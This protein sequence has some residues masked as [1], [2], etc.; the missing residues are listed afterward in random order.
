MNLFPPS[1][2]I[3]HYGH[4]KFFR[5]L[6]DIHGL[7]QMEKIFKQKYSDNFVWA[8]LGRGV[9]IYINFCI[10]VHFKMSAAW[11]CPHS[12]HWCQQHRWQICRRCCWYRGQLATSIVDTSGKFAAGI[13]DTSGKFA[14]GVNNTSGTGGKICRRCCWHRWQIW[15]RCRWY[16]GQFTL[17]C[18]YLR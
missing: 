8:P 1:T 2:W 11:Y 3:Y 10:Q 17:A 4:F 9:N 6:A 16:R 18:E 15:S 14:T 5:K 12:F 7:W 13:V